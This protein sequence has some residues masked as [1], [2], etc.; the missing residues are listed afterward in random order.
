MICIVSKNFAKSLDL[1]HEFD[2]TVWRHKQRT[3]S[4]NDHRTPLIDTGKIKFKNDFLMRALLPG[5]R[6]QPCLM[7]NYGKVGEWWHFLPENWFSVVRYATSEFVVRDKH[8]VSS[9]MVCI[10]PKAT[11]F[12][13]PAE[14]VR[15]P[16][17]RNDSVYK[18]G[19]DIVVC[20]K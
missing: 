1:K 8:H 3:P 4:N 19:R 2:V 10:T 5:H 16:L 14:I 17:R 13:H 18:Q 20:R 12:Q 11:T 6:W 7:F 9:I 15:H